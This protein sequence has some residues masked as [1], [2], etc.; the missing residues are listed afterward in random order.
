VTWE[1]DEGSDV[2]AG[3]EQAASTSGADLIAMATHGRTGLGRFFLGSIAE[4]V[5]QMAEY[6]ILMV[7]SPSE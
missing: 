5:L 2:E 3:I 4:R 7:R 6:P 1:V